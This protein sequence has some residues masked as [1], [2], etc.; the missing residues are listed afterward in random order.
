MLLLL[1]R[2]VRDRPCMNILEACSC[3]LAL[4]SSS[5][6]TGW[7]ILFRN[8]VSNFSIS[9]FSYY[10]KEFAKLVHQL[11]VAFTL[12]SLPAVYCVSDHQVIRAADYDEKRM[13]SEQ[14]HSN[15]LNINQMSLDGRSH[16]CITYTARFGSASER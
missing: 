15:T 8:V 16:R 7:F 1:G 11:S 6:S 2:C 9:F 5:S 12:T 4:S 14:A 13:A 3:R 10:T